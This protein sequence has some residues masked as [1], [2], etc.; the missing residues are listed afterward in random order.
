MR[1]PSGL[2]QEKGGTFRLERAGWSWT[3]KHESLPP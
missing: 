3:G 1:A 2:A